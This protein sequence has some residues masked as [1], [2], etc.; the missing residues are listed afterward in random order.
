MVIYDKERIILNEDQ[1]L[2]RHGLA[3][4]LGIRHTAIG[5]FIALS[6][7]LKT[8]GTEIGKTVI[9]TI[10]EAAYIVPPR[11]RGELLSTNLEIACR[12]EFQ[13]PLK[14]LTEEKILE[15]GLHRLIG[16]ETEDAFLKTL[17]TRP[18]I[19]NFVQKATH[20]E[21]LLLLGKFPT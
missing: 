7:E 5:N 19:H 11:K 8:V 9:Y 14:G 1:Y 4:L 2:T 12:C 10:A 18:I 20:A 16:I 21:L 13:Q 17:G 6:E 15:V 3:D